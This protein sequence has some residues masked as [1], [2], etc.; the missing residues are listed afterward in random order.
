MLSIRNEALAE[1][2]AQ[3][4]QHE[5]KLK[6]AIKERHGI[7]AEFSDHEQSAPMYY[8]PM[9]VMHQ[10]MQHEQMYYQHQ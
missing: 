9:P 1:V 6:Q 4:Q 2:E 5:G 7:D 10:Q 8:Q 3:R